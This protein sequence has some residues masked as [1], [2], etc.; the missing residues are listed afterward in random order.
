MNKTWAAKFKKYTILAGVND[1][2]INCAALF[3]QIR[4]SVLRTEV[5]H[6]DLL[7]AS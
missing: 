5:L 2:K 6:D 1:P 3:P 7:T 4:T